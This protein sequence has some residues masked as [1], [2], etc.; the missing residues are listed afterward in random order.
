MIEYSTMF[1]SKLKHVNWEK[2]SH[3][4]LNACGG[5]IGITYHY[6]LYK[7]VNKKRT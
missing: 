1:L 5:T 4:C 7:E 6:L 3:T 2:F